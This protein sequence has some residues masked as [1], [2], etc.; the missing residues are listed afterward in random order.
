MRKGFYILILLFGMLSCRQGIVSDDPT[1]KLQ[2][3]HDTVLFDTVFTTMGS[4]TKCVMVYNPNEN[5]LCIDQVSLREGRY[6]HINLDGENSMEEL[7]NITL[8]GGD[9][10]FLFVRAYIDP[11]KENSPVLVDD[12]IAFGVNG[13]VQ[14]IQLQAY[15]QNIKRIRNNKG[16]VVFQDL[17]LEIWDK[18]NKVTQ[19]VH[20]VVIVHLKNLKI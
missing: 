12:E 11:Q 4:S 20:L 16:L 6:F 1:L 19:D 14:T 17:T 9:S 18:L 5:A 2:F 10:L 7:R 3:S 13:N 15:G 8:R